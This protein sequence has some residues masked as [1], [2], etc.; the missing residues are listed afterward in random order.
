MKHSMH[1]SCYTASF[2][3]LLAQNDLSITDELLFGISQSFSF[4]YNY[5]N[6]PQS[7]WTFSTI[8][9]T[10]QGIY[11]LSTLLN[12]EISII[13]VDEE[14]YL[15]TLS[16]IIKEHSSAI[17]EISVRDY[18]KDPQSEE[19][20]S[21]IKES[22]VNHYV[23]VHKIDSDFV[24]FYDN[25]SFKIRK[26]SISD[27]LCAVY[28][29]GTN[30]FYPSEGRIFY[31]DRTKQ[32]NLDQLSKQTILEAIHHTAELFLLSNW[33]SKGLNGLNHMSQELS[34]ILSEKEHLEK[35]KKLFYYFCI[36]A[37]NGGLYRRD[38]IKFLKKVTSLYPEEAT[39]LKEIISLYKIAQKKWKKIAKEIASI[40]I[41][42]ASLEQ[43][44]SEIENLLQEVT[45]VEKK[46]MYTLWTWTENQLSKSITF[47]S[48][49]PTQKIETTS[50]NTLE[51]I[52]RYFMNSR[53][54]FDLIVTK[55]NT[56][57]LNIASNDQIFYWTPSNNKISEE[58]WEGTLN[59]CFKTRP[60]KDAT[61]LKSE[62]FIDKIAG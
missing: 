11:T 10:H 36:L 32:R 19:L 34:L 35:N 29:K 28:P 54:E 47:T 22:N 21:Y 2:S 44:T 38:Y 46:A 56:I 41:H 9:S 23:T 55:K 8:G 15:A 20:F 57:D 3:N 24:F 27:F 30:V 45:L 12:R 59:Y 14:S 37:G 58:F 18:M 7:G 4:M 49:F 33:E 6:L 25:F 26:L 48:S 43:V 50:F 42:S 1:S 52:I 39:I 61:I 40:D 62:E 53:I 13:L 17:I 51:E 31:Y 5:T 60:L 16:N